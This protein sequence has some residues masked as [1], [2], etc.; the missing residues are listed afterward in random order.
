MTKKSLRVWVFNNTA[1]KNWVFGKFA[2]SEGI[3]AS[4]L[5][6]QPFCGSYDALSSR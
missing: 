6:Y 1:Q 2:D 4:F 3:P 5:P